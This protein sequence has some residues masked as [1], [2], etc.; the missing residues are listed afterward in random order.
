MHNK[1]IIST[2]TLLV[3]FTALACKPS[4]KGEINTWTRNSKKAMELKA[5]YPKFNTQLTALLGAATKDWKAAMAIPDSDA[6]KK[7]E[8]LKKANEVLNVKLF[9]QL[10]NAD[11]RIT[12]MKDDVKRMRKKKRSKKGWKK[13]NSYVTSA[14]KKQYEASTILAGADGSTLESATQAADDAMSKLIKASSDLSKAKKQ[15]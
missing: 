2:I 3:L 12:S 7:A 4:V 11:Y 5:K 9:R 10:S 15:K 6:E 14:Y 13:F 1:K 8:A